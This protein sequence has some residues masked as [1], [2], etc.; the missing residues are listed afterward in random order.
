[1]KNIWWYISLYSWIGT[2]ILI[3]IMLIRRLKPYYF[4][5]R[6]YYKPY[7]N[8]G[9]ATSSYRGMF[10]MRGFFW[11]LNNYLTKNSFCIKGGR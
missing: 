4:V 11:M 2:M 7:D 5:I 9:R 1:M 10:K 6:A 3:T 8:V